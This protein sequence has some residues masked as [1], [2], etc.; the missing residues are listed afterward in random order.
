MNHPLGIGPDREKVLKYVTEQIL[1][2]W[3]SFDAPRDSE[4]Q[5]S[6]ALHTWLSTSLPVSSTDVVTSIN[7][8]FEVMDASTAQSRP[9]FFAYIGSSGL[10]VGAIAD[11]IVATYDVNQAIDAR[12][13]TLMD[14]QTIGWICDFIGYPHKQGVFTS[15]GMV[16]NLTALAAARTHA[17][18]ESRKLGITKPVSIY[19][20]VESHYS[21]TRAVEVLGMGSS[22]IRSIEID[23]QHRMKPEALRAQIEA[24]I[25]A[26][27]QPIAII[28]TAGTTL[29][30]AIDPIKEIAAIAKEFCIWLHV[31]GAYG[32]PAASTSRA[33][34]FA[35]IEHADSITIDAHKWLFVPKACSLL[36]IKDITLL[37]ETFSHHEAYMPH[38][39]MKPNPVDLT[40]EYSRPLRSLKLWLGFKTHGA[41]AFR[42]AIEKNLELANLTYEIAKERGNYK[43]LPKAPQLSIIP[44]QYI[45]SGNID[46]NKFNTLLCQAIID[47]GRFYISP[48]QID[49]QT[50]L[51]PCYTNFRTTT[52]DVI[53]FFNVIE[54]IA[55][56]ITL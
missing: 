23:E 14:D 54:E 48:A 30:G 17:L 12:A 41:D 55:A 53:E 16:S 8:A 51:R 56:N 6:D 43:L 5:I 20:S 1:D 19:S 52:N 40:L 42:N 29:T 13:A 22:A 2:V 35:G 11:F 26:G 44:L 9:R 27:V 45:P 10:E 31:D 21:N 28:A 3:A 36:L 37:A 47:D 33:P 50:W 49:G 39:D 4:P 15:G 25:A 7:Q 24:D 32:I 46:V 18:P 38:E 34:L